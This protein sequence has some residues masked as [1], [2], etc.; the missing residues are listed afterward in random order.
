M[1]KKLIVI[2][3]I[4]ILILSCWYVKTAS[5]KNDDSNDVETSESSEVTNTL[6]YGGKEDEV[7]EQDKATEEIDFNSIE[8]YNSSADEETQLEPL[9]Q[10]QVEIPTNDSNDNEEIITAL[11]IKSSNFESENEIVIT[12]SSESQPLLNTITEETLSLVTT[13]NNLDVLSPNTDAHIPSNHS[14]ET[15]ESFYTEYMLESSD[16]VEIPSQS[17][18]HVGITE[19]ILGNKNETILD[20]L[21]ELEGTDQKLNQI[22]IVPEVFT[23]EME[24]SANTDKS[25]SALSKQDIKVT[26]ILTDNISLSSSLQND[27]NISAHEKLSVVKFVSISTNRQPIERAYER[28]VLIEKCYQYPRIKN[29]AKLTDMEIKHQGGWYYNPTEMQCQYTSDCIIN[30]NYFKTKNECAETCEYWRGTARCL[31]PPQAGHFHCSAVNAEKTIRPILMVYFDKVSGKCRW[32]TYYGCGGSANRFTSIKECEDTCGNKI[33]DKIVLVANQL[34]QV[35]PTTQLFP[36]WSRIEMDTWSEIGQDGQFFSKETSEPILFD[37]LT[38]IDAMRIEPECTNVG[39]HESRWYL[40]VETNHCQEFAYSHC[41]GSSNNFLTRADCEQFCGAA[42]PDISTICKLKPSF[43]ECTGYKTMWYYDP[44]WVMNMDGQDHYLIGGCRQFNY[45]G[46]GGNS[47]RFPTQAACELTCQFNTKVELQINIDPVEQLG[48]VTTQ[49]EPNRNNDNNQPTIVITES[50]KTIHNNLVKNMIK[51]TLMNIDL[52]PCRRH[53]VF[54]FC[55]P[56][57]CSEEHRRNQTCHFLNFQRW[58]FNAHTS[59]CEAYSYSGCGASENTFDDAQ[60]CQAACKARIVRPD[61]DQRCDSNPHIKKCYTLSV[62]G[63]QQDVSSEKDV[64]AFHFSMSSATCKAFH[65]NTKRPGCSMEQ[66]FPNGYDCLRECVK[67]SPNE[68][69]LQNRCFARKTHVMWNCTDQSIKTYRWSYLPEINQCVRF[70]E[71]TNP[72]QIIEQP[73]NNFASRSECETTCMASSF[74]EVCQLPKDPGPCTS[75]QTRYFYDSN[76][77]KCRVFLYGGCLGNFNRFLSRKE[78]ELACSQFSTHILSTSNHTKSQQSLVE[79]TLLDYDESP[80]LSAQVF[81]KMKQITQHHTDRYPW[82][83]CLDSHSYGTCSLSGGQ[84][85]TTSEYPYVPLTRYYYDRRLGHCQPYTYTGCGARGNH[86]DTLE[87]CQTVCENRLKNPKFARCHFDKPITKCPGSGIQAWAYNHTIGDCYF[88]EICEPDEKEREFQIPHKK[89]SFRLRRTSQWLGVWQARTG[90]LPEGVYATRSA[91]QYHCLPKPP[92]GTDTQNVCHMNPIVT[93]PFGCNAMVTRWYF[94]PRETQ[95]RSYITCPQYGNNF[96][97][98][99]ACQDICTPGHPIDVC[100][101]PY[102][103][104]GCSNFEKRWYYDMHKRMCMP[105]TYGG[106]FGNSNRFVTKAE[107]EGFCMGK[108]VCRLPLQKNSTD[109]SYPERFYYDHSRKQCLPF[110]FTGLLAHGNNFPSLSACNATCIYVP[111]IE[112]IAEKIML[113]SNLNT[114]K[115]SEESSKTLIQASSMENPTNTQQ[116]TDE[117]TSIN[118]HRVPN[119]NKNILSEKFPCLP[120]ITSSQYDNMDRQTFC[121]SEDI[122]HE[123][124]YRF[125]VTSSVQVTDEIIDGICVPI[126]VPICLNEPKRL[127]GQLNIYESQMIGRVFK[128]EA[129]CEATCLLKSRFKRSIIIKEK[130]FNTTKNIHQLLSTILDRKSK[131]LGDLNDLVYPTLNYKMI[132]NKRYNKIFHAVTHFFNQS[133][134]KKTLTLEV[135]ENEQIKLPCWVV[136]Q[137]KPYVQWIHILSGKRY[138]V[139]VHHHSKDKNIWIAHLLLQNTKNQLHTGGW[140]CEASDLETTDYAKA[141]MIL[142][143]VSIQPN[144]ILAMSSQN[145]VS[146]HDTVMVPK[147]GLVFLSCPH[148]Q[149]LG[150]TIWKKNKEEIFQATSEYLII[151]QANPEIHTGIW[152]CGI[153]YDNTFIEL[154]KFNISVGYPPELQKTNTNSFEDISLHSLTCP[155]NTQ[156]E[157]AGYI[158][159]FECEHMN[160][161]Y[162]LRT[163]LYS[164]MLNQSNLIMCRIG[165]IWGMDE[166]YFNLTS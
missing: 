7:D 105:F 146:L 6:E 57:N 29:C 150:D 65:L 149:Y 75:F 104:G 24:V 147:D 115:K 36:Q 136:S 163:E 21:E 45:S 92:R 135:L 93:V 32:F 66:Y 120:F 5:V 73:G 165:N 33:A 46:C 106:C 102:D 22:T 74:E 112:V 132:I 166:I 140:V 159:W 83:I 56:L 161:C 109:T 14:I 11:H 145:A 116:T 70:S 117:N 160:N 119:D 125:Q 51:L 110:R 86:F 26:D 2:I 130:S 98:H 78:C 148:N 48:N 30:D 122:I 84:Y 61:R 81:E 43:G 124:G 55:R 1:N 156:G 79:E 19:E 108:D 127:Y 49:S 38:Y 63:N 12:E 111:D 18:E 76:T 16:I 137:N 52:E 39:Q 82:D 59:N 153:N 41:G 164:S 28:N 144:K 71:C 58:F 157:P 64:I 151:E 113:S 152:I 34:C 44:N 138:P 37:N 118:V 100:R 142:N 131:S 62:S 10:N 68:K 4:L 88:F 20:K 141:T 53:P 128:T 91:C 80:P 101:L 99:K 3:S 35:A 154:Y 143:V 17:Q 31:A 47:N 23:N 114:D 8:L 85:Q 87:K 40:D 155:I 133:N 13:D 72:D 54:G 162:P 15:D 158:K 123:L 42:K 77:S 95:C 134:F 69:H 60:A 89:F 96:P 50:N 126:L 94:E 25:S 67:S 90:N 121:N 97:S 129:E 9:N 27:T 107:C 139:T 103:H